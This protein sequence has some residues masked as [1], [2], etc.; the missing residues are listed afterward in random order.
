VPLD[1][2]AFLVTYSGLSGNISDKDANQ[3]RQNWIWDIAC[4]VVARSLIA[5]AA[6]AVLVDGELST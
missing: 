2:V 6:K 3:Q 1:V 5:R 4:P